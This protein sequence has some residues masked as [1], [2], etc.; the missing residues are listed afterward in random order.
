MADFYYSYEQEQALNGDYLNIFSFIPLNG[1]L[2]ILANEDTYTC[3]KNENDYVYLL[4]YAHTEGCTLVEYLSHLLNRF[5]IEMV[6]QIKKELWGQYLLIIKQDESI[7]IFS[8]ILQTRSIYYDCN[9]KIVSSIFSLIHK[10]DPLE[11]DDYKLFEFISM[12]Y[13]VHPSWLG[14][15]TFDKR[16]KRIRANEYLRINLTDGDIQVNQITITINNTKTTSIQSL[17]NETFSTLKKVI[18]DPTLKDEVVECTITG[19]FDSR[20]A[21][22]LARKYYKDVNLRIA[23]PKGSCFEDYSIAVKIAKMLSKTITIYETDAEQQEGLFFQLTDGLS[24]LE[25]IV[26]TE[27]FISKTNQKLGIGGVFG[28]EIY[29]LPGSN[30]V[31]DYIHNCLERVKKNICAKDSYYNKLANSLKESLEYINKYYSLTENNDIDCIRL[32]FLLHTAQFNTRFSAG[33]NLFH[34]QFEPFGT[35]PVIEMAFR[36][37]YSHMGSSNTLGRYYYIPKKIMYN[38]DPK[39][40]CILTNRY[41]PMAPLNWKT[42]PIYLKGKYLRKKQK[43]DNKPIKKYSLKTK[44]FQCNEYWIKPLI[45]VYGLDLSNN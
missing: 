1:S 34:R 9:E 6:E 19:G 26:M 8:D 4:G 24:P 16:I 35:Y 3:I 37:P 14:T 13:C 23:K 29:T 20:L 11:I 38:L 12:R 21:M 39:I 27:L 5:T 42:L 36:I 2:K 41:Y 40:A 17:Y 22:T 7:Y 10:N 32:F 25:N 15:D 44:G 43:S 28:T 18:A 30:S 33:F 45:S 31:E